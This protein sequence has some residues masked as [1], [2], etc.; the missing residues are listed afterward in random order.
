[1]GR[2]GEEA[3][4]PAGRKEKVKASIVPSWIVNG[5]HLKRG[6]IVQLWLDGGLTVGG[7][8]DCFDD[9]AETVCISGEK[10]FVFTM[11]RVQHAAVKRDGKWLLVPD[12]RKRDGHRK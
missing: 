7:P 8:L 11:G 10:R 1:M 2:I 5:V 4:A 3:T 6:D 12:G 9:V